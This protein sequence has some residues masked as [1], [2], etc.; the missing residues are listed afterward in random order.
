MNDGFLRQIIF[1]GIWLLVPTFLDVLLGIFRTIKVTA[2][3][4]I[5]K[6]KK[7][8]EEVNKGMIYEPLVSIIIPVYN[9][10]ATLKRCI[11]SILAQSYSIDNIEIILVDNGST[12]NSYSVFQDIQI[13]NRKLRMWWYKTGRGKA[14]A[15][16]TGLYYARGKYIINIDSD[17]W[18]SKDCIRSF[19]NKFE[20]N[21]DISAM[22][23]S[24]IIETEGIK[25]KKELFNKLLAKC[26]FMEY[27]E[28][29][30]I[31]RNNQSINNDIFTMAGAVSAIRSEVTAKSQMYNSSIVGED[32]HMT[33]QIIM[34]QGG[35]VSYCKDAIFYTEPIESMDKLYIQRQRWQRGA[36]EVAGLFKGKL[37]TSKRKAMLK[38]LIIDHAMSFPKFIWI[39]AMFYLGIIGY[40]IEM[41]LGAN[42]IIYLSYAILSLISI[43]C[44]SLLMYDIKELRKYTLCNSF[45]FIIMPIYRAI[46]LFFRIAGIV[47]S[48]SGEATWNVRGFKEEFSIGVK[49]IFGFKDKDKM[50][51]I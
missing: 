32:A 38:M 37:K 2:R 18:I 22:T 6:K 40:P 51:N 48:L 26:E 45:I 28:I 23:G 29:F 35:K 11:E 14:K 50:K 47:N 10:E 34:L 27:L 33:Q 25:N 19:I 43:I 44:C 21:P 5:H 42:L 17:G 36:L 7:E 3:D 30:F 41:I 49:A 39:F 8:K 20:K 46:S 15:L 24:V 16:N 9:S 13:H 12:D 4:L 1:W 31:G